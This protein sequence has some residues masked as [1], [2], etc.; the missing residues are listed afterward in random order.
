MLIQR[1]VISAFVAVGV[2]A[3]PANAQNSRTCSIPLALPFCIVGAGAIVAAAVATAPIRLI[4]G[5][6]YYYFGRPS[7]DQAA[8][9]QPHYTTGYYYFPPWYDDRW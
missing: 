8:Y 1:L 4:V 5:G 7:Y 3:S 9:G 2:A 6:Q